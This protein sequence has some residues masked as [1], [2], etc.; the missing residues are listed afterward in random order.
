MDFGIKISLRAYLTLVFLRIK[1]VITYVFYFVLNDIDC[2]C[3]FILCLDEVDLR[4]VILSFDLK[5]WPFIRRAI[6]YICCCA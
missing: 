2:L 5:G 4:D 6:L 3:V 1:N